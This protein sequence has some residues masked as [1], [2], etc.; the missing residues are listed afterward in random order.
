MTSGPAHDE[1]ASI[2]P[3]VSGTRQPRLRRIVI[4]LNA[5]NGFVTAVATVVLASATV[6]LM[7]ATGWLA[8]LTLS[9]SRDSAEQATTSDSQLQTLKDQLGE[10]EKVRVANEKFNASQ[11][12]TI[13][14]QLGIMESEQRAWLKV[15]LSSLKLET[16]PT[17]DRPFGFA[18]MYE[19]FVTIK[20]LGKLP[21]YS[22]TLHIRAIVIPLEISDPSKSLQN[23]LCAPRAAKNQTEGPMLFP[24]ES[25]LYNDFGPRGQEEF[26]EADF[27]GDRNEY[28]INK[29]GKV[30]YEVR[31]FGCVD[32]LL[33]GDKTI[34]HQTGFFYTVS[35]LR[36]AGK[37]TYEDPKF[38]Y[39]DSVNPKDI[40]LHSSFSS[41]NAN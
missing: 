41:A 2:H 33:L 8:F 20:N 22:L 40:L 37:I 9:L 15:S 24:E 35:L 4:W 1:Q 32:Y 16:M 18:V 6:G 19:P 39:G 29:L 38:T 3:A 28:E 31:I 17:A 14:K 12:E 27:T 13:R 10:M 21:A 5:N 11:I 25:V 26:D 36:H 23:S 7:G 34:Y 30:R